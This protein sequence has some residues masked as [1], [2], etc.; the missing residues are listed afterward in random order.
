MITRDEVA[1]DQSIIFLK[2]NK[3]VRFKVRIE[4][5]IHHPVFQTKHPLATQH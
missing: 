5:L 2:P 3:W 4:R 1:M